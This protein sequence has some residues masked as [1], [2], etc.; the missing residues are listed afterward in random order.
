MDMDIMFAIE[1]Y[2]TENPEQNI[3]LPIRNDLLGTEEEQVEYE[4]AYD[5]HNYANGL[6]IP[7]L[8]YMQSALEHA[9]LPLRPFT[10]EN[11][12]HTIDSVLTDREQKEQVYAVLRKINPHNSE[13]YFDKLQSALP[14]INTFIIKIAK[15]Q[16]IPIHTFWELF[17]RQSFIEAATAYEDEISCVKGI[18]ERLFSGLRIMDPGI[19]IL[20][21]CSE[22]IKHHFPTD[23][24]TRDPKIDILQS[25]EM[26]CYLIENIVKENIEK[27]TDV[28]EDFL[29]NKVIQYLMERFERDVF[30]QIEEK[31]KLLPTDLD[32]DMKKIVSEIWNSRKK[33][34]ERKFTS[35]Q[36]SL[37]S[38]DLSK[39]IDPEHLGFIE[40]V[41][42]ILSNLKSG[43]FGEMSFKDISIEDI[44]DATCDMIQKIRDVANPERIRE[45]QSQHG[46]N[47][48]IATESIMRDELIR[49]EDF[50]RQ[51]ISIV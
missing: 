9:H 11:L 12:V 37:R 42:Q 14:L 20:F 3:V 1:T 18:Y 32:F 16:N 2:V 10:I 8:Q 22:S 44:S 30:L 34:A 27:V 4:V 26:L 39:G 5:V 38:I 25:Q 47:E 36:E 50:N 31:M 17:I 45:Q 28:E 48:L 33:I 15:D 24:K 7:C 35:F 21:V 41:N 6:S 40:V 23:P 51:E 29:K 49:V 13:N 43:L 19:D 46:I